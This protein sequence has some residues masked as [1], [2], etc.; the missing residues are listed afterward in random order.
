MGVRILKARMKRL[1]RFP[2]LE[3]CT[4]VWDDGDEASEDAVRDL[5]RWGATVED[6]EAM[7]RGGRR[8]NG[9][10]RATTVH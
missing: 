8:R 10:S 6:A 9:R 4:F 7:P 2:E 3:T 1:E 5:L